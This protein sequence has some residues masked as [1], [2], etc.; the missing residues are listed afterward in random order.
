MNPKSLNEYVVDK[1]TDY[2]REPDYRCLVTQYR[3]VA[4]LGL[5]TSALPGPIKCCATLGNK[6]EIYEEKQCAECGIHLVIADHAFFDV[7]CSECYR[8][9][10]LYPAKKDGFHKDLKCLCGKNH[11]C[12]DTC[13]EYCA[14]EN[15]RFCVECATKQKTVFSGNQLQCSFYCLDD[16]LRRVFNP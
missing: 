2:A 3:C 8:N 6:K 15:E 9:F 11:E 12:A 14:C 7:S 4:S 16:A 10:C 5:P 13:I 1:I